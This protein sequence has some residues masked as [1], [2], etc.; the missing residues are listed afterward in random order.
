M[1]CAK[2]TNDM[3]E[4]KRGDLFSY[5]VSKWHYFDPLGK[6]F[7]GADNPFM[8]PGGGWVDSSNQIK[9]PLIKRPWYG[10]WVELLGWCMDKVTMDLTFFSSLNI[11]DR[12]LFH[13][14]PKIT[15]PNNLI[16]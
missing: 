5:R 12:I 7:S 16:F 2:P 4:N 13:G 3:V 14:W 10:Q 15:H 11:V 1:R 6:V 9:A 8:T